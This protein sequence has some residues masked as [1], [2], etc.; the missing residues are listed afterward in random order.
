[1]AARCAAILVITGLARA[2]AGANT[3]SGEGY[4]WKLPPGFPPPAVPARNPMSEAKVELGQR[5]FF[6]PRL[7]VTHRHACASCHIPALGYTDGRLRSEGATGGTLLRQSMTL[8]NVGY[9]VSLGWTPPGEQT[10]EAQMITPMFNRHPVELGLSGRVPALLREL[11]ADAQMARAF[12]HAFPGAPGPTL[13]QVIDSIAC[14]ERSLVSGGSPFDRYVFQDDGAALSAGAKRGMDLFFGARLGCSECHF[15][16]NF[17]GPAALA[18]RPLPAPLFAD[19]GTQGR[20]KVPTLRN[21]VRTAPYMHDGRFADLTAVLGHYEH[22]ERDLRPGEVLD[23][24][25]RRFELSPVERQ[26]VIEFLRAL[27]DP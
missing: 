7:S 20:F 12:A 16:V 13:R 22:P 8:L 19:T 6:D 9:A 23:S 10:L 25:I 3:A 11:A 15:G 18:G 26:E 2:M 24:R 27:S 5:L 1:M 14:F 21:L 4:H 17:A